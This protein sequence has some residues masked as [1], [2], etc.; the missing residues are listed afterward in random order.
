MLCQDLD[1]QETL[2]TAQAHQHIYISIN[3]G[4]AALSAGEEV[5]MRLSCPVFPLHV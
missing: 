1:M 4:L 2:R 5:L 3:E